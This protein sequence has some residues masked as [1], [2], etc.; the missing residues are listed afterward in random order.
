MFFG[1]NRPAFGLIW[2]ELFYCSKNDFFR[3]CARK[4]NKSNFS[5][6][7]NQLAS[8]NFLVHWRGNIYKHVLFERVSN[9]TK[10]NSEVI[11]S[12]LRILQHLSHVSATLICLTIW[13]LKNRAQFI[14]FDFEKNIAE[15]SEAQMAKQSFA[16]KLKM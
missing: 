1:K 16:S 6:R 14:I 7:V 13:K 12:Q 5:N 15:R 11:S 2:F 10:K 8:H 9:S 4:R 3:T